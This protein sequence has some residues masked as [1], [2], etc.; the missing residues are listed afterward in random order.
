MRFPP[1][2]IDWPRY[3]FSPRREPPLLH[4]GFL[5]DGPGDEGTPERSWTLA[6]TLAAT[7]ALFLLVGEP[8]LGKSHELRRAHQRERDDGQAALLLNAPLKADLTRAILDAPEVARWLDRG[9]TSQL[10]LFVDG[11]D[12]VIRRGAEDAAAQAAAEISAALE[13]L[14]AGRVKLCL[15]GRLAVYERSQACAV[16]EQRLGV[17][18]AVSR[19]A[20][21]RHRDMTAAARAVLGELAAGFIRAVDALDLGLLASRPLTL[22]LLLRS[23]AQEQKL[24]R[25]RSDVFA[26]GCLAL[27]ERDEQ[28]RISFASSGRVRGALL[29]EAPAL[30]AEERLAVAMRIAAVTVLAQRPY[31]CL[32]PAGAPD[33]VRPGDIAGEVPVEPVAGPDAGIELR[34]TP[35]MV[36]ETVVD[37]G[38]FDGDG[39]RFTW[40]HQEFADFLASRWLA[41]HGLSELQM[42]SLLGF[43]SERDGLQLV[44]QLEGLAAWIDDDF[45][46][47]VRHL[48]IDLAPLIQVRGNL[49]GRS[50]TDKQR[51]VAALLDAYEQGRLEGPWRLQE[52]PSIEMLRHPGLE[53]QLRAVLTGRTTALAARLAAAMLAGICEVEALAR[54]LAA[55]ATDRSEPY[56]LRKTAAF[57]M[58]QLRDR[59]ARKMLDVLLD[60]PP[61]TDPD[62]ALKGIALELAWRDERLDAEALFSVLTPPR[63]PNLLGSYRIFLDA[64]NLAAEVE[65]R[66]GVD[67]LQIG[68]RW[69]SAHAHAGGSGS[70]RLAQTLCVR[71][72]AHAGDHDDLRDT[73]VDIVCRYLENFEDLSWLGAFRGD[74]SEF[75]RF[76]QSVFARWRADGF[77]PI[78]LEHGLLQIFDRNDV[79][80]LLSWW[81]DESAADTR[82]TLAVLIR[83]LLASGEPGD[84]YT[85]VLERYDADPERYKVFRD[86]VAC[87][88]DRVPPNRHAPRWTT[89]NVE[90]ILTK[91]EQGGSV[92]LWAT[93]VHALSLAE[94]AKS[95]HDF[96]DHPVIEYPGW[97][98]ADVEHRM[99]MLDAAERFVRER[100]G[101]TDEWLQ[102]DRWHTG[103]TAGLHA[104]IALTH[105]APERLAEIPAT[106]W[107]SWTPAIAVHAFPPLDDVTLARLVPH[108]SWH[109]AGAVIDTFSKSSL[110]GLRTSRMRCWN[111]LWMPGLSEAVAQRIDDPSLPPEILDVWLPELFR[112]DAARAWRIVD[113]IFATVTDAESRAAGGNPPWSR[114]HWLSAAAAAITHDAGARWEQIWH[115]IEEDRT[116]GERLLGKVSKWPTSVPWLARLTPEQCGALFRWLDARH[117]EWTALPERGGW[118]GSELSMPRLADALLQRLAR[119]GSWEALHT[120]EDLAEA[121]PDDPEIHHA[122][123]AAGQEVR[124]RDWEPPLPQHVLALAEDRRRYLLYHASQLQ[125][126]II[127]LVREPVGDWASDARHFWQRVPD[128]TF[129]PVSQNALLGLL[130]EAL[131]RAL[132]QIAVRGPVR[133][134][135]GERDTLRIEAGMSPGFYKTPVAVDVAVIPSWVADPLAALDDLMRTP[136]SD[137]RHW[138]VLLAWFAG[139]AWTR[140][141][142]HERRGV[143]LRRSRGDTERVLAVHAQGLEREHD[144]RIAPG[145][146]DLQLTETAADLQSGLPWGRALL[147]RLHAEGIDVMRFASVGGSDRWHLH[148][149]WPEDVPARSGLAPRVLM[150]AGS[151]ALSWQHV[152]RAQDELY[153]AHVALDD[154]LDPD[155][156]VI[157]DD[158]PDLPARVRRMPGRAGQYVAWSLGDPRPLADCVAQSLAGVDVFDVRK[159]VRGRQFIGREEA[160]RELERR[161]L[162][163]EGCGVFG[164]RKSGKTSLVH[165][166]LDRLDP[167]SAAPSGSTLAVDAEPAVLAVWLDVQG[168]VE[169]SEE[170][171][172]RVLLRRAGERLRAAGLEVPEPEGEVFRDLDR[173]LRTSLDSPALPGPWCFVFDEA[174]LLFENLSG[175][176]GIPCVRLLRFLRAL[177]Q[178]TE[179]VATVFIGRDSTFLDAPMLEGAQNPM[180][181]WVVPFWMNRFAPDDADRLLTTLGKRAAL[182][183]DQD[184][185]ARA[186]DWSS[187]HVIL[188]R[189]FGAALLALARARNMD[190]SMGLDEDVVIPGF[191]ARP[192]VRTVCEET[193]SLLSRRYPAAYALLVDLLTVEDGAASIMRHGGWVGTAATALRNFTLL[194]GTADGPHISSW[195]L[196]YAAS[197]GLVSRRDTSEPAPAQVAIR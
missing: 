20:P 76:L 92:D 108:I 24:A 18:P 119:H 98:Q 152:R 43:G 169:R 153:V 186:Q 99:R 190:T 196:W 117:P 79:S 164:L 112:H 148:A 187:G 163:S 139:P 183:I 4:R 106:V 35:R 121:Y 73:L 42:R 91:L 192:A 61:E 3:V 181:G 135:I 47:P 100:D 161:I 137:T 141:H 17:Q 60:A 144:V 59:E 95:D 7:Q 94:H 180:L 34:V 105:D 97:K 166:V 101:W 127:E 87:D 129:M 130:R 41:R 28:A 151:G 146:L 165:A 133:V 75:R 103:A 140:R 6:T 68:L 90:Q 33:A 14:P 160:M 134:S 81:E 195:L 26:R 107:Q 37:T 109:A 22:L 65:Q 5:A 57:A 179:R 128:D 52:E 115:R 122:L 170:A 136:A 54:D 53:A 157:V 44:P 102:A 25:R 63:R 85:L 150:L 173:L 15:A 69:V 30:S 86:L 123:L 58:L 27:C 175:G 2:H 23:Y 159:P 168:L 189:Q 64:G 145:T 51:I 36:T 171:L 174:D 172:W 55:L 77:E 120:L 193:V 10:F 1:D 184:N 178:E 89:A 49:A 70:E 11:L 67:G 19:L 104:W 155:V 156:L 40:V 66:F 39:H 176:P 191:L 142:D 8:G 131:E 147:D 111:A 158:S 31:I 116:L 32:D 162:G 48:V 50:D 29:G 177:A 149:Q 194:E 21:L 80:W 125:E 110:S 71:A 38:L 93:L 197:V 12:E 182:H 56:E 82:G 154:D 74:P 114:E 113:Q 84:F 9:D 167:V 16:L 96:T 126:A 185:L 124:R 132:G 83:S 13:R 88:I 45:A 138:I 46:E 188:L 72:F 62:D 143:A 118:V 78:S